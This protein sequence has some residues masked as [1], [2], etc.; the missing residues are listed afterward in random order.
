M[1]NKIFYVYV[2]LDSRKSGKYVY[3]ETE[4]DFEPFYVGKGMGAR[5]YEHLYEC[6]LNGKIIVNEFKNNIIKKIIKETN[7]LPIIIKIKEN[8]SEQEAFNLEVKMIKIIGRRNLGKGP[9]TNLT[10]GGEGGYIH[11]WTYEEKERLRK[12]TIF[13]NREFIEKYVKGNNRGDPTKL[14]ELNKS[15]RGKT[16]EERFGEK[17]AKTIK[18]KISKI[19][20]GLKKPQSYI[21]KL[22]KRCSKRWKIILPN[23]E[24]QI[25]T[26]LSEYCRQHKL[27]QGAM[28]RV[29]QGKRN[30]YK[31][32]K[33]IKLED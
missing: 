25:I 11:I 14:I 2:Y 32:Y 1:L 17:K 23:T 7:Q 19:L 33:C 21:D 31:N 12:N 29:S 16:L 9:L 5:C 3:G 26:N 22:V 18:N 20:K 6:N 4:F 24:E 8:L 10:D 28:V 15:F 30:H 27:D 13:K